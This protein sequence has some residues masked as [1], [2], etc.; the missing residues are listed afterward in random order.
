MTPVSCRTVGSPD[1]AGRLGFRGSPAILASGRDRFARP[2][3]P[4]GLACRLC[5]GA[6]GDH[7]PAAEQIQAVL[8]D[9]A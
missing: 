6:G 5:P 7:F 8:A 1:E 4:A 3:G 9:A 2:G